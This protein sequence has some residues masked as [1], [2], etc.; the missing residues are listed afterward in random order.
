MAFWLAL[1]KGVPWAGV[2]STAPLVADGAKQLWKAVSRKPPLQEPLSEPAHAP[3]TAGSSAIETLSARVVA[4]ETNVNNLHA[5][6]L[7]SS[8][9]IKV[10]ADQNA[11]LIN[12]VEASRVRMLWLIGIFTL[13]LIAALV[14]LAIVSIR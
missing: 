4:L 12:R 3:H 6:M 5:Q 13:T 7:K 10:L 1:L 8:E 14:G 11:L 2:I 9:L